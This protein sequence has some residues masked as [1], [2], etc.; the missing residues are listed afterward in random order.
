MNINPQWKY[1]WYQWKYQSI[2]SLLTLLGTTPL[3]AG[4]CPVDLYAGRETPELLGKPVKDIYAYKYDGKAWHHIPLQAVDRHTGMLQGGPANNASRFILESADFGTAATAASLG[5]CKGDNQLRRI[6]LPAEG[7]FAYI[8]L[9]RLKAK[10]A[11]LTKKKFSYLPSA[12]KF[13]TPGIR[14]QHKE[15]NE[16]LF[17]KSFFKVANKWELIAED[18][19]FN[20]HLNPKR[21]FAINFDDT[22]VQT[23]M[24]EFKSG[25]NALSAN[26][27]FYLKLLFFK[28]NLRTDSNATF[29][30]NSVHLP[31]VFKVPFD[32]RNRLKFGS[33]FLFFWKNTGLQYEGLDSGKGMPVL[34]YKKHKAKDGS[35]LT[36]ALKFCGKSS[37]TFTMRAKTKSNT[38]FL[39]Q[40]QIPKYLVKTGFFPMFVSKPK[41][42]VKE[43]G[44]NWKKDLEGKLAIYHEASTMH[45]G[46]HR[47][48]IWIS[49]DGEK[50]TRSGPKICPQVIKVTK[51]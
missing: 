38:P 29:F 19:G 31:M 43:M 20:M 14:Y 8:G 2:L 23:K 15:T 49:F 17:T 1:Q 3:L 25:P 5:S 51:V 44:W 35:L 30:A 13:E 37:C 33:G 26:L 18:A 22:R 42:F 7:S 39:V 46:L 24:H 41:S 28:I 40:M 6:E 48:D 47:L 10:P 34:D 4:T 16:F 36:E 45:K 11:S 27:S 12:R 9:C 32:V 21:F 50:I